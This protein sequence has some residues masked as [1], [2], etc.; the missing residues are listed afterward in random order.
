[1]TKESAI[2]KYGKDV[3][4]DARKYYETDFGKVLFV[5]DCVLEDDIPADLE[6]V[7]EYLRKANYKL[8]G[9]KK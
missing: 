4:E 8:K 9:N 1:M 6:I 3:V 2:E 5:G 7:Q